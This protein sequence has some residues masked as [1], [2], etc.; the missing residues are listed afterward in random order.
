[1]IF[2]RRELEREQV[3]Y[4]LGVGVAGEVDAARL[5]VGAQLAEVLDDPVVDHGYPVV[6]RAVWVCVAV[7]RAAMG[8]PAG[9]ADPGG[10]LTQSGCRVLDQRLLQVGELA[11]PLL[12]QQDAVDNSDAGRVVAAVLQATKAV[13]HDSQ[14]RATTGVTHDATHGRDAS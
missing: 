10:T 11:G 3:G 13:E 2:E 5:Q 4:A 7:G 9:M 12:G 8:G 14:R 6:V 1:A